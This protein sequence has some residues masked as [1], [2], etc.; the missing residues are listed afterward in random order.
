MTKSIVIDKDKRKQII[1]KSFK[2]IRNQEKNGGT[3]MSV[4]Q[5]IV[6]FME[7]ELKDEN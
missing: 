6:K 3:K 2:E 7:K 5:E 1:N 4:I